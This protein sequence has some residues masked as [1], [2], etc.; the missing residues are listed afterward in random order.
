MKNDKRFNNLIDEIDGYKGKID[1]WYVAMWVILGS[2]IAYLAAHFIIWV[3]K[4]MF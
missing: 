3:A 2:W 4:T 1:W